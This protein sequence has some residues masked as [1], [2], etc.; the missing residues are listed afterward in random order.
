MLKIETKT[1]RRFFVGG[2]EFEDAATARKFAVDDEAL[3]ALRLLLKASIE[4]SLVQRGNVD[5]VLKNILGDAAA[6]SEILLTYRKRQPK[7]IKIAA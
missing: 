7:A 3:S 5:N 4:S 1:V 6:V 2:K